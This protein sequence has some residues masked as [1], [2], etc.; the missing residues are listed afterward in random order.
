M[1]YITSIPS[2]IYQGIKSGFSTVANFGGRTV[3]GI[4]GAVSN[5][6]YYSAYAIVAIANGLLFVGAKKGIDFVQGKVADKNAEI[7]NSWKTRIFFSCVAGGIQGGVN[8]LAYKI[9]GAALCRFQLVGTSLA[10]A[11]VYLYLSGS[12]KIALEQSEEQARSNS[13]RRQNRIP[14]EGAGTN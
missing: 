12:A 2:A 7:A 6:R 10:A 11:A 14:V 8:A 3:E 1:Y 13:D 9:A 4:K 5:N